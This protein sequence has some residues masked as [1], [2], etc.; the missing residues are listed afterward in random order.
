MRQAFTRVESLSKKSAL[1]FFDT[2]QRDFL[3]P[4]K[5][6]KENVNEDNDD[7]DDDDEDENQNQNQDQNQSNEVID[8]DNIKNN[9]GVEK[10]DNENITAVTITTTTTTGEIQQNENINENNTSTQEIN[11][12]V[13][14]G[15]DI[16]IKVE[17]NQQA[18]MKQSNENNKQIE[19][20]VDEPMISDETI[21]SNETHRNVSIQ[22]TSE[23][24]N[25]TIEVNAPLNN[26]SETKI[27]DHS[28]EHDNNNGLNLQI[29]HEAKSKDYI[30]S[31]KSLGANGFDSTK[32]LVPKTKK[33]RSTW[34][35][36]V[37][38]ISKFKLCNVS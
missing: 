37:R 24:I 4:L 30:S 18:I 5:V 15:N 34:K 21:I 2:Q 10:N 28:D 23:T 12:R 7:D 19:V 9:I 29:D 3:A 31:A 17:F 6:H 20:K 13:E 35:L 33:K 36:K 11:E 14:D 8:M 27:N 1:S 22:K 16:N 25:N 38:I 26:D 32:E